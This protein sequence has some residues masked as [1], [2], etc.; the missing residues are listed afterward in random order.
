MLTRRELHA[1]ILAP[2]ATPL[3][4]AIA[5]ATARPAA[6]MTVLAWSSLALI[7]LASYLAAFLVARPIFRWLRLRTKSTAARCVIAGAA[8]G[9]LGGTVLGATLNLVGFAT[10]SGGPGPLSDLQFY[11]M[12]G[13]VIGLLSSIPAVF[14]LIALLNSKS[15]GRMGPNPSLNAD[16]PPAGLRPR[17]GP[18][19]SLVR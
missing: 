9:P 17:S 11:A 5:L 16:V 12:A 18:P 14:T 2:A 7:A 19:V 6:L 15:W 4:F 1:F 3:V 10:L 8:A 13:G